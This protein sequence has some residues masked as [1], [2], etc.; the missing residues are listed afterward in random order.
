MCYD[1]Y[2]VQIY[3]ESNISNYTKPLEN[4]HMEDTAVKRPQLHS[5]VSHTPSK[6][7]DILFL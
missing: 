6:T 3:M 7:L 2:Q 5:G 1:H 4:P